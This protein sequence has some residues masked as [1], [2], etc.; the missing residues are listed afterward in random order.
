MPTQ[1][2]DVNEEVIVYLVLSPNSG[3][4]HRIY[5]DE[6][7]QAAGGIHA[8]E[9]SLEQESYWF[10]R[11]GQ[12]QGKASPWG[13]TMRDSDIAQLPTPRESVWRLGRRNP[14]F[15]ASELERHIFR[16]TFQRIEQMLDGWKQEKDGVVDAYA[17]KALRMHPER[18]SGLTL[19]LSTVQ[20]VHEVADIE[21][22]KYW[23]DAS[24]PEPHLPCD[25]ALAE[26]S[27]KI[28]L[29]FRRTAGQELLSIE[30]MTMASC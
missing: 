20:K 3:P 19:S 18:L 8:I 14:A 7:I 13:I 30:I 11:L 25:L 6:S 12:I 29:Q 17:L 2:A 5:S 22:I 16:A 21:V 24:W 28:P 1:T 9:Q 26:F 4:E 23:Y 15:R 27:L 10:V